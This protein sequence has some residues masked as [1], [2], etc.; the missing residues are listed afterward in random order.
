MCLSGPNGVIKFSGLVT[1]SKPDS[2]TSRLVFNGPATVTAALGDFASTPIGTVLPPP[3][4]ETGFFANFSFNNE[5]LFT[6][7]DDLELWF[8]RFGGKPFD[9]MHLVLKPG[10]KVKIGPS[11]SSFALYGSGEVSGAG[12]PAGA[13]SFFFIGGT[14][15]GPQVTFTAKFGSNACPDAGA[16]VALLGLAL[17]CVQVLRRKLKAA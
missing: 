3:T 16:T 9:F 14:G 7:P 11:S 4:G 6:D 12:F 8:F 15:T 17:A 1:L 13:D 2:M 10:S 5:T